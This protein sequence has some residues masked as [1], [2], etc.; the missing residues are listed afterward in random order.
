MTEFIEHTD[1]EE[2]LEDGHG[3]RFILP[4]WRFDLP[5]TRG[6]CRDELSDG[7]R[8]R[9]FSIQKGDLSANEARHYAGRLRDAPARAMAVFDASRRDVHPPGKTMR[10]SFTINV[11]PGLL[12]THDW[13][14]V[15]QYNAR[16]SPG[17]RWRNPPFSIGVRPQ[18]PHAREEVLYVDLATFPTAGSQEQ[19]RHVDLGPEAVVPL[20][21]DRSYAVAID[22]ADGAGGEGLLKV[23]V[24]D[25]LIVDY[26]GPTGYAN[27]AGCFFA[28]GLYRSPWCPG[29]E[30]LSA[31][32]VDVVEGV[33]E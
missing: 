8:V 28:Y 3:V 21:R 15:S 2:I 16:P 23:R 31:R 17:E 33:A 6:A 24:D 9:T 19:G 29:C 26:A 5:V 27:F 10:A 4:A 32:F 12:M 30:G 7:R 13:C 1:G 11:L 25:K 22:F 18:A 20:Q 14:I